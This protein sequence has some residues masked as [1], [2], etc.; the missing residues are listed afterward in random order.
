MKVYFG[1]K[2]SV[3]EMG[4]RPDFP[5]SPEVTKIVFEED[6]EFYTF[7]KILG[8]PTKFP[9]SEQCLQILNVLLDAQ[10]FLDTGY[11]SYEYQEDAYEFQEL[12]GW[13]GFMSYLENSNLYL[14]LE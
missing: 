10:D 6:E 5:Q 3:W 11:R 1:N 13:L 2:Q 8:I 4:S 9:D 14:N 12:L 7:Q